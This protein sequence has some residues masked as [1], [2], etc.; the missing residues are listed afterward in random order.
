MIQLEAKTSDLDFLIGHLLLHGELLSKVFKIWILDASK[1]Q[2]F[3]RQM[4]F[5]KTMRIC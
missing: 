2:T 4:P 3:H 5:D 1:G